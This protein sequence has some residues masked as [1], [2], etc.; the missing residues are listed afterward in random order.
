MRCCLLRSG[1][2]ALRAQLMPF[3]RSDESEGESVGGQ[4][5]VKM[6]LFCVFVQMVQ[7][8]ALFFVLWL[9]GGVIGVAMNTTV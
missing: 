2:K 7:F 6:G 3:Q 1:Y 4:K 8:T 9:G 5:L